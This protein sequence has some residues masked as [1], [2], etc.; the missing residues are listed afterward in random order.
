MD[1]RARIG[2]VL[3]DEIAF[4]HAVF[5]QIVLPYRD[6]GDTVRA[7]ER[8]QGQV[9]LHLEAGYAKDPQGYFVPVGLPYGPAAR[10]ILCHLNTEALKTGSPMIDV[11]GSM[12]AFVTRLHGFSPDGRQ[13]RKFKEQVTH[14]AAATIRLAVDCEDYAIQKN[15][16]IVSRSPCGR[17]ALKES[18]D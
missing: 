15:V 1:S 5:C 16:H 4:Q 18:G 8:K 11:R 2:L 9:W 13:I 12:T 7:W 14:L 10:L 17:N 6:P 3:P